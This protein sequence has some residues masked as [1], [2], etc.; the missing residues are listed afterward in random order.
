MKRSI[1]TTKDGYHSIFIEEMNET[2]HSIHGSI[3]ESQHIY[4]N[5]GIKKISKRKIS[6][7]EVGFGTG[8]NTI[9]T[10]KNSSR[11]NIYYITLEPFPLNSNIYNKLNFHNHLD[12][13]KNTFQK[14]H[15]VDWEKDVEISDNF[16]LHKT[17]S[18][19]QDLITKKKFDII[20]F[21]AFAPKKQPSIWEDKILRKCYLLLKNNGFLITYCANG[22]IKRRLYNNGFNIEALQG[23]PGGKRSITKAN[24]K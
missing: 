19:I 24:Q 18:R 17:R 3:I 12:I 13:D 14:I 1:I 8:L 4:I 23:P 11:K 7:L 5:N 9:L 20:Y 22:E 10:L 21:D 16:T 6:V 2:Y 15:K